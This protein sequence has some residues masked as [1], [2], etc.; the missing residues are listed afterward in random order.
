MRY[1]Y[2]KNIITAYDTFTGLVIQLKLYIF[3]KFGGSFAVNRV[4]KMQS[5]AL[6]AA[7]YT[8]KHVFLI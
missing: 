8:D 2:L 7:T 3:I 1:C 5:R 6:K 4:F